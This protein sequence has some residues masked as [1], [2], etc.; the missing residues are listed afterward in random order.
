MGSRECRIIGYSTLPVSDCKVL[1]SVICAT[2]VRL[3]PKTLR[4]KR[5]IFDVPNECKVDAGGVK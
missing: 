2:H 4:R 3:I 5:K 1:L